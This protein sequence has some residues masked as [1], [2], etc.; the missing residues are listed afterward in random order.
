MGSTGSTKVTYF[1][2]SGYFGFHL[3]PA[4][5]PERSHWNSIE[6]GPLVFETATATLAIDSPSYTNLGKYNIWV[7]FND[8]PW[9]VRL[10]WDDS[11]NP[12][13]DSRGRSQWGH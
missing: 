3:R 6:I 8:S 7:T 4:N 1:V 2:G 11:P 10:F 12:K 9:K 5:C 13:H